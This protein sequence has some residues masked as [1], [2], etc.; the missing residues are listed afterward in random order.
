[1]PRIT[2]HR[3]VNRAAPPLILATIASCVWYAWKNH[4]SPAMYQ[5]AATDQLTAV[6]NTI[7]KAVPQ[8][9]NTVITK[10]GDD[11]QFSL[12]AVPYKNVQRVE[13]YVENQLIG[14][15]YTAPY[16]ISV[17]A[18][19]MAAGSHT[20]TAKIVTPAATA[21]AVPAT[22]TTPLPSTPPTNPSASTPAVKPVVIS[23][24]VAHTVAAPGNV[25]VAVGTDG[26]NA[27]LTWNASDGTAQYQIWRDGTQIALV[28]GTTYTDTGVVGGQSYVY[29]LAAVDGANNTSDFS[30]A[31]SV[32]MPAA[33]TSDATTSSAASSDQLK[34]TSEQSTS[35]EQLAS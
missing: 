34:Q 8:P 35:D 15:A 16:S 29:Q 25:A 27:I 6:A 7:P 21:A 4:V 20:A 2:K 12:Q 17:K 30:S 23:T 18:S 11:L 5:T 33:S 1:M 14:A 22:F 28:A 10:Q 31:V 19:N 13:F 24:P 32:T 3:W 9:V 26:S